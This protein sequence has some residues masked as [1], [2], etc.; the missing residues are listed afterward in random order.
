MSRITVSG[1]PHVIYLLAIMW[2]VQ[3]IQMSGWNLGS[4]GIVPRD[5]SGLLEIP[6]APWIH[7]NWW[8]LISNSI[9]FLILG[10]LVQAKSTLI[11]WEATL[12]IILIAG[13]GTW[14]LGSPAYHIGASGLVLGYLSFIIADAYFQKSIKAILIA[15]ISFAIYG[16]LLFTLLDF[17]PHISWAGHASGLLAGVVVAVL[18]RKKMRRV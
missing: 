6:L 11:F 15:A 13:T 17:R 12:F 18:Y 5:L 8:H 10:I 9:P 3:L 14:L 1:I 4:Y 16:G 2:L 7:H